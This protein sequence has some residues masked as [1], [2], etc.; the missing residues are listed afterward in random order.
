MLNKMLKKDEP[1]NKILSKN[2]Q[3]IDQDLFLQL[4]Q[5]R[6]DTKSLDY[7]R[8]EMK[9]AYKGKSDEEIVKSLAQVLA[10]DKKRRSS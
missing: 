9:S 3:E 10:Q 6:E 4:E 5:F 1:K 8:D 7:L 2:T